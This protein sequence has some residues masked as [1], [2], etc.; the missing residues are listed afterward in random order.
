MPRDGR[1]VIFVLLGIYDKPE[2]L[3]MFA[4]DWSR[5]FEARRGSGEA[6][7][8]VDRPAAKGLLLN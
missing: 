8:G 6:K 3:S 4:A 2:A 1:E 5:P 7:G